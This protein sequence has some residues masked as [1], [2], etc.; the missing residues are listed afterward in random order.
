MSEPRVWVGCLGCYNGGTL[1]GEWFDAADAPLSMEDFV[2]RLVGDTR[3][4][5][6]HY[7]E[8]HEELWVM[9]HEGFD[10]FLTGECSPI[11][12]QRIAEGLALV[13]DS[14]REPWV[15]YLKDIGEEPSEERVEAFREQYRGGF[16]SEADFAEEWAYDI[17]AVNELDPMHHYI[18]WERYARDLFMDGFWSQR[19]SDGVLHVFYNN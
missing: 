13:D 2:I 5:Q 15:L 11:E 17:G 8:A 10:G 12:A 19:G 6:A 16:E 4:P 14:E 7:R 18:D 3:L 9:D 1:A